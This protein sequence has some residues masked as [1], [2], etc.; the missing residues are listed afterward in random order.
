MMLAVCSLSI[1]SLMSTLPP[2][3]ALDVPNTHR[4]TLSSR[5]DQS[6]VCQPSH[7]VARPRHDRLRA[8]VARLAWPYR[9]LPPRRKLRHPDALRTIARGTARG[10][11][12]R[13]RPLWRSSQDGFRPHAI[14]AGRLLRHPSLVGRDRCPSPTAAATA[15]SRSAGDGATLRQTSEPAAKPLRCVQRAF[16]SRRSTAPHAAGPSGPT[17][18][19]AVVAVPRR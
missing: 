19:L 8:V 16:Y 14:G 5:R 17:A 7:P 3:T 6:T 4:R 15:R 1:V 2:R 9:H 10:A 11:P 12:R 13:A 18:A